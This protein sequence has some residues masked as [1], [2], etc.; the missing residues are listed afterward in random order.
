MKTIDRLI[1][2][3]DCINKAYIDGGIDSE[4]MEISQFVDDLRNGSFMKISA[5]R[6][7]SI[8]SWYDEAYLGRGDILTGLIFKKLLP[9]D[10]G[11]DMKISI[12]LYLIEINTSTNRKDQLHNELSKLLNY[13]DSRMQI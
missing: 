4:N 3:F 7:E 1:H 2:V 8:L 10:F 5:E 11:L 12:I 6:Q 9:P 13:R